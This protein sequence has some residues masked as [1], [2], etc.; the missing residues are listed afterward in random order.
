MQ[1]VFDRLKTALADRYA[2]ER[3]IGAGGMATVY[4]AEDLKLH[5]Q[6][7]IKVLRPELAV[8][9]GADRFLQEIEVTANLQHPNILQ[10]YEADEADELLYYVM[11]YVEGETL[12]DRLARDGKL[13][14]DDALKITDDIAAA[15]GYAHEHGIVHRDIKPENILLTGGR[16]V[17]ADFGIARAVEVAGG[18]RLTGTGLAVGT[19]AYMSPEQAMA[20]AEVDHRSDVYSLGCVLYEM[21]GGHAPFTGQTPRSVIAKHAVDTVPDLHTSEPSIPIY[22][23]RAVEK[24]LAKEP[25]DRFQSVGEFVE[26]LTSGTVVRAVHRPWRLPALVG[27]VLVVAL[28]WWARQN[29]VPPPSSQVHPAIAV[30]PFDN[31]SG[32]PEQSVF[33]A[34]L[35]EDLI[36]RLASWRSF[37][38]IARGSSFNPDLPQDRQQ[39]GRELGARYVVEGSVREAGER[40]RI[41][42]QVIDATT[43]RNVWVNQY[44]RDFN[45][46]LALQDE[47][48]EAIVGAMNP[49]LLEF[50]ADRAMRQDPDNLDAWNTAMRGWWHFNQ[51]T[52]DDLAQA[53]ELFER[54]IEL[55]PQWGSAYAGLALAHFRWLAWSDSPEQTVQELLGA[56]ERAVALDESDAVAH[57]A[58]G[59]AFAMTGQTDKMIGAFAR[60]VELNPSDAMANFCHGAH[61]A[62]VGRTEEAIET[63]THAMSISPRDLRAWGFQVGMSWAHFAAR[64][65]EQA[66]EWAH[67]SIQRRPNPMGYQVAAASSAHLGQ[68]DQAQSSLRELLRLQPDLSIVGLEQFFMP[69]DPDFR[70]RLIDGLRKAGLEVQQ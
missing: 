56:A 64:D 29:L 54:A 47:I 44:D 63:L 8:S 22:V 37:P 43:G 28:G 7:A 51:E 9:L 59:H 62:W 42:V 67:K 52:R 12:S 21:I 6:V 26:V 53:V 25:S 24:A 36:T 20:V 65:Y 41:V 31:L 17:V 50:E 33:A 49:A 14:L 68:L 3:E 66:L 60:G 5:R 2:I 69:A 57:H 32:D 15:L 13:P 45:D 46:I 1:D 55:D 4:V 58:L 70:E 16:A 18:E 23:K 27:V 30:L 19:P 34:G 40:V 39:A 61:L 35:A 10:L 11:P 38:V 48:S